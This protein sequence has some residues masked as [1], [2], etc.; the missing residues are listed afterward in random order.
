MMQAREERL[1]LEGLLDKRVHV[2]FERQLD[3]DAHRAR[4]AGGLRALVGR[5]HQ[6][7][8]AAGDDVAAQ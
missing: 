4:R 3:A 7:R 1:V 8:A 6:A 5:L 2:L